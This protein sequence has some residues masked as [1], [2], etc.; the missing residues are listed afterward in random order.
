MQEGETENVGEVR[1]STSKREAFKYEELHGGQDH[2]RLLTILS[3][4]TQPHDAIYCTLKTYVLDETPPYHALSYVWGTT[5]QSRT[6]ICSEK[7]LKITPIPRATLSVL[8]N[9]LV[10]GFTTEDGSNDEDGSVTKVASP[11]WTDQI[12]INQ[13]DESERTQQV[14]IMKG[15]YVKVS[16]V[17]INL[18][19]TFD[20]ALGTTVSNVV[21]QI[22]KV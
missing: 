4:H 18:G 5:S 9:N 13:K 19:E 16:L 12:C 1:P 17:L 14:G 3:D 10:A 2:I 8:R 11:L 20:N 22:N 7:E 21:E 6:I 15:I